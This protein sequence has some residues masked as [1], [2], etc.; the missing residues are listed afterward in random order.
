[1]LADKKKMRWQSDDSYVCSIRSVVRAKK[2]R[3]RDLDALG[4]F[5]KL[6]AYLP[7]IRCARKMLEGFNRLLKGEYL[8]Y[9]WP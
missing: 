5:L 8:I 3:H 7:E 1:L 6:D 9:N 4:T 2:K